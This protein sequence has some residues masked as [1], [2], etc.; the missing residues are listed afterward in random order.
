[1][2]KSWVNVLEINLSYMYMYLAQFVV[3]TSSP[4]K[5]NM[6]S[7]QSPP[8]DKLVQSSLAENAILIASH[9]IHKD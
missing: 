4:C 7:S 6:Y 5:S 9:L 3:S 8:F 1:M 2:L